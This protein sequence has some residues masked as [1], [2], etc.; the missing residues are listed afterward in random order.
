MTSIDAVRRLEPISSLPADHINELVAQSRLESLEPGLPVLHNGKPDHQAIYLLRGDIEVHLDKDKRQVISAGSPEALHPI[1]TEE[2]LCATS[3]VTASRVTILRVDAELLNRLLT[4]A[5][6]A[7]PEEAVVMTEGRI[8]SVNKSSWLKTMLKSATFR[9][10]PPTNLEELLHRLEPIL[11]NAGQV[12][13]RQGD[14]GDYFY[15]IDDGTA[16]VTHNPDDDE[17]SIVMAELNKGATFGEAALLTDNPRNATVSMMSDGV[18]LR[19]SKEDFNKLLRAPTLEWLDF[20]A[21]SARINEGAAWIDVRLASE[22]RHA[23]L[24]GALNIPMPSLHRMARELDRK[25]R[26]ICYCQTGIR[27]AAAAFVL[28]QYGLN[29]SALSD[30]LRYVDAGLLERG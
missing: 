7:V 23:H 26:Y 25:R 12:I 29:A 14:Q 6:I 8:I 1:I 20:A 5:Q 10:L 2:A 4:W 22:Y 21:A 18:L 13:I 9:N 27:S 24:P 28:K 15:M 16:L 30:G 19:L 11:V 17:D 3:A